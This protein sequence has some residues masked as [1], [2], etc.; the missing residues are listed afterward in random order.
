MMPSPGFRPGTATRIETTL[1]RTVDH[2]LALVYPSMLPVG[3]AELL[4]QKGISTLHVSEEEFPSQGCNALALA[5]R[6][7]LVLEGNPLVRERLEAVGCK[8]ESYA[9]AEISVKGDGGP[10]CLTRPLRR[11]G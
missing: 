7:V 6:H 2:D 5:P 3:L 10:T 4:E 1:G 11:A 9:G 8:V